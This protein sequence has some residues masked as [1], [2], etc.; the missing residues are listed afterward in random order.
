MTIEACVKQTYKSQKICFMFCLTLASSR[1]NDGDDPLDPPERRF[2]NI[3]FL[4]KFDG[5][6]RGDKSES[7]RPRST[8]STSSELMS[9]VSPCLQTKESVWSSSPDLT[10]AIQCNIYLI[11]FAISAASDV[12]PLSACLFTSKTC[13]ADST[14]ARIKTKI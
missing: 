3:F 14:A 12:L 9:E 11:L 5:R 1:D 10:Q 7:R 6:S 8:A 4:P 13:P 2:F